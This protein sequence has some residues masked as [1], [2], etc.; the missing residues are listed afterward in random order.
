MKRELLGNT[1]S[2]SP[3]ALPLTLRI[4]V[5]IPGSFIETPWYFFSFG[6]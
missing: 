5:Q 6:I 3:F 1:I 2:I 4:T